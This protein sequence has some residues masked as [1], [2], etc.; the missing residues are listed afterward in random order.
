M[1]WGFLFLKRVKLI[2]LEYFFD[3]IGEIRMRYRVGLIVEG[4][5]YT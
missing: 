5:L 3:I 2:D 4:T 1:S